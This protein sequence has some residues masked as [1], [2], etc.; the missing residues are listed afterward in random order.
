MTYKAVLFDLDG[1]LLDTLQDIADAT[2]V[3][4]VQF[5]FPIYDLQTYRYF[6][7]EGMAALAFKA[8]PELY[9]DP[10][11]LKQLLSGITNEYK[12]RWAI[13]TK[14]YPGIPE[15][16]DALVTNR[17]KMAVLSNKPHEFTVLQVEKLLPN[18]NF[19]EVIGE[20]E[21]IPRKPDPTGALKISKKLLISPAEFIYLGDT[22]I[23]MKTATSAGMYP[24][25]AL[26]GFRTANELLA[27]GA[28]VLIQRPRDLLEMLSL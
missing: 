15:L 24:V 19:D 22:D 2:N 8:L 5:G 1:T 26:W 14:P 9:R 11:T 23:D 18:W 20:C 17:I 10:D 4:L 25:G 3:V 13:H 21:T 6:V 16:L 7:G 27:G 28:K 12:E